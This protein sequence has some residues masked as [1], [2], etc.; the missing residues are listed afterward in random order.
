MHIEIV[1][2]TIPRLSSM[3]NKTRLG[4]LNEL[5]PLY[6]DVRISM[7]NSLADL[8]AIARRQP[9]LVFLGMKRLQAVAGI[10]E[11]IWLEQFFSKYGIAVTGSRHT[12]QRL[13]LDKQRA[14]ARISSAGLQTAQYIVVGKTDII[15]IN[16]GLLNYPL[17]VKPTS[18]GGGEGVD[19]ESYV[20]N[21]IQLQSKI[22]SLRTLHNSDSMIEEYLDGREFSVA[23][24]RHE[25]KNDLYAMPIELIAPKNKTGH[26]FL[27]SMVKSADTEICTKVIDIDLQAKLSDFAI[28]IFKQL[29]AR[30]YGR[31]DIRLDSRGT[32]HFLEANLIPSLLKDYGNFPKACKFYLDYSYTDTILHILRLSIE[33]HTPTET[34]LP[35]IEL[36]HA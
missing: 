7:V 27:S 10:H 25:G 15:P 17:L 22:H 5:K 12:A 20:E 21:I 4:I 34:A 28:N 36:V 3:G 13:E 30:D 1:S 23:I 32:P 24:L 11:D 19:K 6:S 9:D 14:K 31:I 33:R 18:L 35:F 16:I 8:E 29:G 2:T 26:R